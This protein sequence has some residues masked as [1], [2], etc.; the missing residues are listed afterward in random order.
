MGG[1]GAAVGLPSL[2]V[3][4]HLY[5]KTGDSFATSSCVLRLCFGCVT[6]RAPRLSREPS[7]PIR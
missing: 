7:E 5:G 1:T 6:D 4:D 2:D 3:D